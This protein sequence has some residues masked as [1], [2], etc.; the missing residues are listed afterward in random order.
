MYAS[1]PN[2]SLRA[3]VFSIV[4]AFGIKRRG[5]AMRSGGRRTCQDKGGGKALVLPDSAAKSSTRRNGVERFEPVV[6][7][8]C[9]MRTRL[10]LD[11]RG[12]YLSNSEIQLVRSI[13]GRSACHHAAT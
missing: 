4:F 13:E 12:L 2:Y 8:L 5:N 11:L 6:K 10:G 9:P 7:K 1:G 3:P